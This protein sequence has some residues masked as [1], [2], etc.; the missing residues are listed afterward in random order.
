[1][2]SLK[3]N[4]SA[5]KGLEVLE[6][7]SSTLAL[8]QRL[9]TLLII[10]GL[11]SATMSDA[12]GATAVTSALMP[13]AMELLELLFS[14]LNL[15]LNMLNDEIVQGQLLRYHVFVMRLRVQAEGSETVT[16]QCKC[17]MIGG[18]VGRRT[19]QGAAFI[20][21]DLRQKV[22][23]QVD[24]KP[25]LASPR[26]SSDSRDGVDAVVNSLALRGVETIIERGMYDS[27]DTRQL[28]LQ[29]QERS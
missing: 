23:D 15:H 12:G 10:D 27:L 2:G 29:A 16:M 11:L 6:E 8:S 14:D 5:E 25:S 18:I 7:K 9:N 22:T 21:I 13:L 24:S 3:S 17:Q 19:N 28:D 1:M 26:R 4:V 20:S